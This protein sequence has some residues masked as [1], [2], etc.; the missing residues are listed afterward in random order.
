MRAAVFH[1]D[2]LRGGVNA[3]YGFVITGSNY[4]QIAV[5]VDDELDIDIARTMFDSITENAS[6]S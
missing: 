5:Y 2:W 4:I 1:A 3:L 6:S